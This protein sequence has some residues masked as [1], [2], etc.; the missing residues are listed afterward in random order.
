MDTRTGD[1]HLWRVRLGSFLDE[2]E[3]DGVTIECSDEI[4]LIKDGASV[5]I[6]ADSE[7]AS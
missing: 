1:V 7:A 2:M 6:I 4:K 3:W 5:S